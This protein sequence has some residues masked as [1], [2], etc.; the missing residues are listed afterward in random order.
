MNLLF[1]IILCL[2]WFDIGGNENFKVINVII[3]IF[4]LKKIINFFMIEFFCFFYLYFIFEKEI[5][6]YVIIIGLLL[7]VFLINNLYV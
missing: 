2:F 3:V 4:I 7:C 6:L 5:E 1:F